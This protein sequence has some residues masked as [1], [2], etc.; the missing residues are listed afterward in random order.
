MR[1][2]AEERMKVNSHPVV[3]RGPSV[4]SG[5]AGHVPEARP[6]VDLRAVQTAEPCAAF[7]SDDIG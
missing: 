7:P 4:C 6:A 1:E 2:D 5:L 3:P